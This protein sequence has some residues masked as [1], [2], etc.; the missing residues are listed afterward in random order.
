M[1][2]IS[3]CVSVRTNSTIPIDSVRLLVFVVLVPVTCII[4]IFANVWLVQY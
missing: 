2:F 4:M 3:C 1:V